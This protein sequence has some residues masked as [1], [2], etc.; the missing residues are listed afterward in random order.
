MRIRK[1]IYITLKK[2][3]KFNSEKFKDLNL[4]YTMEIILF[5][6]QID[7]TLSIFI[8]FRNNLIIF[9]SSLNLVFNKL[10]GIYLS[11]SKFSYI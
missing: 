11:K 5:I 3:K 6:L 1:L 10:K 9:F 4:S 8:F 7:Q 2:Q